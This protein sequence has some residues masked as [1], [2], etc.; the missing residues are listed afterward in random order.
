MARKARVR[1]LEPAARKPAALEPVVLKPAVLKP[2]VLKPAARKP[3]ARKP[4]ARKHLQP[5][6]ITR[7]IP[8]QVALVSIPPRFLRG[9]R[10][11]TNLAQPGVHNALPSRPSCT[12]HRSSCAEGPA[13]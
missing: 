13:A 2:A 9:V 3:A 10:K 4:A 12:Y 6:T 7:E 1:L 5:K 8:A 11:T